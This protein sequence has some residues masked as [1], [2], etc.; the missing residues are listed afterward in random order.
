[1]GPKAHGAVPDRQKIRDKTLSIV[2]ILPPA[3]SLELPCFFHVPVA[4]IERQTSLF[5]LYLT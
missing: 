4:E 3:L 5:S 2:P 1:M